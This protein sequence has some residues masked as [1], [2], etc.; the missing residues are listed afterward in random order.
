MFHYIPVLS[1]SIHCQSPQTSCHPTSLKIPFWLIESQKKVHCWGGRGVRVIA[2][3]IVE[4]FLSNLTSL[5]C[6]YIGL[7]QS[8][9]FFLIPARFALLNGWHYSMTDLL[10][11]IGVLVAA[12]GCT[13]GSG[14]TSGWFT[15][16]DQLRLS[17]PYG[18][19][20][21]CLFNNNYQGPL[22]W[23]SWTYWAVV[24]LSV[25]GRSINSF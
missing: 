12:C 14:S 2:E 11:V 4:K 15:I 7:L 10:G 22:S 18:F 13:Q 24:L 17:S 20:P 21:N 9:Y 1:S 19:S 3:V 5:N 8:K 16:T 25:F 6:Y 23:C